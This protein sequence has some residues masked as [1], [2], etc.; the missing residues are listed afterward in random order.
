MLGLDTHPLGHEAL[1]L[2]SCSGSGGGLRSI[3]QIVPALNRVQFFTSHLPK[4]FAVDMA[5]QP[6]LQTEVHKTKHK[7]F[8]SAVLKLVMIDF[9]PRQSLPNRFSNQ[10]KKG[11]CMCISWWK[12]TNKLYKKGKDCFCC[13][14]LHAKTTLLEETTQT[15]QR[16]ESNTENLY[17]IKYNDACCNNELLIASPAV[18]W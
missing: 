16:W 5:T 8:K 13:G 6:P 9:L 17:E 2:G 4:G 14:S 3:L 15:E 11:F 1:R 12:Y 10:T 7:E 18:L